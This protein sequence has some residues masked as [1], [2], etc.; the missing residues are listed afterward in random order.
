[1][2]ARRGQL[3]LA[4]ECKKVEGLKTLLCHD[5]ERQQV[6]DDAKSFDEPLHLE[7]GQDLW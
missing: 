7:K 6:V 2:G 5:A 3:R 4:K 1:M